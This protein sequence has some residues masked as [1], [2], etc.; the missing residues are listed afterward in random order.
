MKNAYVVVICAV[1]SVV[2]PVAFGLTFDQIQVEQWVGSGGNEAMCIVDFGGGDSYAFGYRWDDGDTFTR[3]TTVFSG[4]AGAQGDAALSEGMLL[5]LDASTALTIT[6]HY[7]NT[8]GYQLDSVS[9]DGHSLDNDWDT[10]FAGY[11]ISGSA[12]WDEDI[13]AEVPP[14]SGNWQIVDTIPHPATDGDGENWTPSGFGAS[15]RT[16]SDGYW[17]AWTLEEV[18]SGFPVNTPTVPLVPGDANVDGTVDHQDFGILKAN[19]GGPG[20][21]GEGDFNNDGD[22]DL[23]DFGILKSNFAG[24]AG[25]AVPEP[26]SLLLLTGGATLLIRRRRKT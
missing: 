9:Y 18:A 20:D 4:W 17:D 19:F 21:W 11:W 6:S 16:L 2:P 3:P 14:G 24:G 8:F 15:S 25:A 10:T 23:Q 22:I 5:A 7:H 1:V 13:W 12:A 26:A